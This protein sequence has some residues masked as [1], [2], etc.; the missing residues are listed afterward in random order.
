MV[1]IQMSTHIHTHRNLSKT[2][3]MI[4]REDPWKTLKT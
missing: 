1:K 3:S 4:L 2:K